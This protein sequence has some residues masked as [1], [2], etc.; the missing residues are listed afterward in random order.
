MK[1]FK[2]F[3]LML[4]AA[5]AAC[6]FTAC[7]DDDDKDDRNSA[8][9]LVGTWSNNETAETLTITFSA[10]GRF[11]ETYSYQAITETDSGTYTYDGMILTLKY[12]DGEVET[13]PIVITG[14]TFTMN[15][16]VYTKR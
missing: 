1:K 15:D 3:L 6:N 4:V 2:F 9:A 13:Y 14:K 8:A 12:D 5:V 10:D 16:I 11:V 7:K